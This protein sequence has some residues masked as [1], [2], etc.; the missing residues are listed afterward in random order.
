MVLFYYKNIKEEIVNIIPFSSLVRDKVSDFEG[1]VFIRA[2]HMNDCVR[3]GV[4]PK[5]NKEKQLPEPRFIDGPNLIVIATPK[6]DLPPAIENPNAFEL[7]VKLKERVTEFTGIAVVRLK[8]A[9]SGDRYGIQG[10][11]NDKGEIP[12]VLTFDEEDLVQIDPP[13]P[14]PKK[15]DKKSDKLPGPKTR[16]GPHDHRTVMAR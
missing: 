5:I 11:V 13:P 12:E 15:D 8:Y 1:F 14:P 4:Q 10:K 6:A 3:Y 2:E 7:G 9:H 16:N